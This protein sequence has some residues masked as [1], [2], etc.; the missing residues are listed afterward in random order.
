M[1]RANPA[2]C[3]EVDHVERL[4]N[5]QSVIVWGQ[6]EEL[7]G[8][9]ADRAE[10]V[11]VERLKPILADQIEQLSQRPAPVGNPTAGLFVR[12]EVVFR[13]VVTERTGRYAPR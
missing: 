6:F 1:L 4:T 5:W 12:R 2:V 9:D 3:F 11:L 13:I 7:H 8:Q 10:Q